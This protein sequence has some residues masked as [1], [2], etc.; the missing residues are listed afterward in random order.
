ME[1]ETAGTLARIV[2]PEGTTLPIGGLLAVIATENAADAELDAFVAGFVVP[3]PAD[4][5]AEAETGPVPRDVDAGGKRLRYLELGS[6]DGMPVVFLHG[7]GADLNSWMFN[8]PALAEGGRAIALELPGHGGSTKD[9]GAGDVAALAGAVDAALTALNLS[10]A[11][12]VGH[13]MGGAVAAVL[14]ARQPKAIASLTL[15]ASGGLG[16][17]IN[18]AFIDGLVKG[19]RRRD[20][21]ATLRLLVHDPALVSRAMVEDVL[22][23]K[24]IDGVNAALET[25][26]A[27]L[28]ANGRQTGSVL[29][30]VTG[31]ACPVQ[32]I[33]G[34]NDQIIPAAHAEA[35]SGRLP[36][37]ILPETGH[38][39]H[40]E[41]S[42]QVNGLI[43]RFAAS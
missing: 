29:D 25:I 18:A 7:F 35:L 42:A 11:H 41:R 19:S 14:A 34:Q 17:E 22:R 8:Q 24:R 13:S 33:W 3:E 1:S 5:A 16:L 40:M 28:F 9:V 4:T 12:L 43:R 10:R 37:H 21:E 26:A 36:V 30:L 39:P 2:A 20:I 27:A 15:I 38:L 31:L 32:L 23:Y 6:G